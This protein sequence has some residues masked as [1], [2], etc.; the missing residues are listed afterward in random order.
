[1]GLLEAIGAAVAA[2]VAALFLGRHQGRR[3]ARVEAERAYRETREKMDEVAV[4]D[5]LPQLRQWLRER[6]K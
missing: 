6:S 3:D 4:G 1:M 5:D 2:I